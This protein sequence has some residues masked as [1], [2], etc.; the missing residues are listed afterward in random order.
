MFI[1]FTWNMLPRT[2]LIP[3]N[4]DINIGA[5]S[6]SQIVLFSIYTTP[7][8]T[9]NTH[10]IRGNIYINMLAHNLT[11]LLAPSAARE[12]KQSNAKCFDIQTRITGSIVQTNPHNPRLTVYAPC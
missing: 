7:I 10:R 6:T 9:T 3:R 12:A 1:S 2:Q 5:L 8:P 4:L 11:H